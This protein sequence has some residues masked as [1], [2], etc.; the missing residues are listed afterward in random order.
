MEVAQAVA[1]ADSGECLVLTPEAVEF[2]GVLFEVLDG[3]AEGFVRL[4][5]SSD[6]VIE[7]GAERLAYGVDRG[8]EFLREGL[9]TAH[10]FI[11]S[12]EA[13]PW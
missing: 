3:G 10:G 2:L 13:R 6:R 5:D 9:L 8:S 12:W 7:N 11:L 4:G 1:S